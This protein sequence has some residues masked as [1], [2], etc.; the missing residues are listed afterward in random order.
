MRS[1]QIIL[2]AVHFLMVAVFFLVGLFFLLAGKMSYT[3]FV[4]QKFVAGSPKFFLYAGI[5]LLILSVAFFSLLLPL[6]SR[7]FYQVKMTPYLAEVD[8]QIIH[9]LVTHCMNEVLASGAPPFEVAIGK[10]QKIEIIARFP[11]TSIDEHKLWLEQIQRS[12]SEVFALRLGYK[13]EFLF[14]IVIDS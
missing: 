10:D 4:W 2:S 11:A 14:S 7:V 3:A 6:Y 12:L 8:P 9:S 13:K 1:H 5:G